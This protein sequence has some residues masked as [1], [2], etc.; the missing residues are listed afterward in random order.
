MYVE[1][2][3]SNVK[4][5]AL[6]GLFVFFP[7]N[8]YAQWYT[9]KKD[10]CSSW[11]E[12]QY[13]ARLSSNPL[14]NWRTSCE[15]SPVNIGGTSRLPNRCDDHGWGG[16]WGVWFVDDASCGASW[17]AP[18]DDGC[19]ERDLRRYSAILHDIPGSDW[20]GACRKTELT[21]GGKHF[22]TPTR[23]LDLG[24]R[25]MW[26]EFDVVDTSCRPRWSAW[27][28]EGCARERRIYSARLENTQTSDWEQECNTTGFTFNGV[29]YEK[30][31][32]CFD[33]N[34]WGMWGQLDIEDEQCKSQYDAERALR[35]EACKNN[36]EPDVKESVWSC[37][38]GEVC[39]QAFVYLTRV[40]I[41]EGS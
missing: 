11:G 40:L 25:G 18:K 6:V 21:V 16:M 38:W 1:F 26:G 31:T 23:C 37:T 5:F 36:I 10:G 24:N 30:P 2:T 13:S 41:C 34:M 7:I 33:K 8:G 32:R 3:G 35:V 12:R 9:V 22:S 28:D 14:N 17:D 4:L 39:A 15:K 27:T 29:Q 20:V 19:V